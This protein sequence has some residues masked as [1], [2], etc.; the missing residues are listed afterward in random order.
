[1][2][3]AERREQLLD[4]TKTLVGEQGWHAVSIEAIARAAGITR[5]VVYGHFEDLGGVL[6]ALLE[7]ETARALAQLAVLMP[8]DF[9][10]D[11]QGRMVAAQRAYL[12]AVAA[13]PVTWTLVLLPGEGAPRLLR[14]RIDAGRAM[15]RETLA[16]LVRPAL[17][18]PDPELTASMLQ[19]LAE[20]SAR[21]L[22]TDP[23]AFTIERLMAQAEWVTGRLAR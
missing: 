4:A 5:P 1:M 17:D 2:S 12:E 16:T 22:L 15:I 11:P 18:S 19:A 8:D 21:L 6:F 23:E 7:R 9:A 14:E 3:G 13:D 10:A 20:E